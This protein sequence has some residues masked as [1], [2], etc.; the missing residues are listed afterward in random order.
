MIMETI[1]SPFG[2]RSISVVTVPL[3]LFNLEE[4]ERD[5][6]ETRLGWA[7]LFYAVESLSAM[8]SAQLAQSRCNSEHQWF[9]D[10][11]RT[12]EDSSA[13][14]SWASIPGDFTGFHPQLPNNHGH[15]FLGL[16]T[17]GEFVLSLCH[18]ADKTHSWRLR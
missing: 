7:V 8:S 11:A 4:A 2:N 12:L 1:R 10:R 13:A 15:I 9:P 16:H 5:P 17:A 14:R 18:D 3:A 6:D